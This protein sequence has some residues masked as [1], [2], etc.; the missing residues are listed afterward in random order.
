MSPVQREQDE[1]REAFLPKTHNEENILLAED[2]GIGLWSTFKAHARLVAEIFMGLLMLLLLV[3]PPSRMTT[4]QSAVPIFPMKTYTFVE[5]TKYLHEDMFASREETLHTLHNWIE[6]SSDGRGFVQIKDSETFN[7][8]EPYKINGNMGTD[9]P[10]YMMSVFHQLH[11]LSYL[12]QQVQNATVSGPLDKEVAHHTA[13][14]FDY[15]RQSIMCNAD[16]SLEGETEAGPGWGSNHQCKDY[17]EVLAWANNHT[18]Y[19]WKKNMPDE[20]VL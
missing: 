5:N 7:I 1:D 15:L 18:V 16:T 3:H 9:E 12:V 6:L 14:C 17:D 20:A 8:G 19:K 4:Q 11:C 2:G 13:H 10:V